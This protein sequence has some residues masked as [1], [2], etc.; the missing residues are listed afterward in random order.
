MTTL[1]EK[2]SQ[3]AIDLSSCTCYITFLKG[4]KKKPH[5]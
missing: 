4:K 5:G 2:I 3:K 1:L